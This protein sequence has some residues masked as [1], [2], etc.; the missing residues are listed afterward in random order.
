MFEGRIDD[1]R[2]AIAIFADHIHTG[3]DSTGLRLG[4]EPGGLGAIFGVGLIQGIEL[5]RDRHTRKPYF[6]AGKALSRHCLEGGLLFSVR[7]NGSVIRF[8]PPFYSTH[9][10]LDRASEILDR[11]LTATVEELSRAR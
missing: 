2:K 4:E 5:V 11:G 9:G 3:L 8:V 6:D 1:F 10:E 7:R